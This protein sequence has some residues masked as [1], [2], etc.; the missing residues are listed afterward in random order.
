MIKITAT[1]IKSSIREKPRIEE[2]NFFR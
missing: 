1:T 2:L